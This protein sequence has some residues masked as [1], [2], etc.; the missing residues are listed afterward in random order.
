MIFIQILFFSISLYIYH[1]TNICCIVYINFEDEDSTPQ[2]SLPLVYPHNVSV[3]CLQLIFITII[4]CALDCVLYMAQSIKLFGWQQMFVNIFS[5]PKNFKGY[6]YNTGIFVLWFRW[7]MHF[8][9]A[10][11]SPTIT[12]NKWQKLP[13][14]H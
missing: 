12:M 2:K 10:N 13:P 5:S 1:R 6:V 9:Q 8:F 4:P 7:K 11:N 14:S 3:Y